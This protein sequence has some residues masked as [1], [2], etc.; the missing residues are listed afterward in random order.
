MYRGSDRLEDEGVLVCS[1]E[2][3][4]SN[5]TYQVLDE[6][7]NEISIPSS[8]LMKLRCSWQSKSRRENFTADGTIQ[9][10]LAPR[11]AAG[12]SY[13]IDVTVIINGHN[14]T[15]S[16]EV[17]V[18]AD[19]PHHWLLNYRSFDK[20]A[21]KFSAGNICTEMK[22][23]ILGSSLQD[24]H[25]NTVTQNGRQQRETVEVV[26]YAPIL[27]VFVFDANNSMDIDDADELNDVTPLVSIPLVQ[28]TELTSSVNNKRKHNIMQSGDSTKPLFI[29]PPTFPEEVVVKLD[30]EVRS[31]EKILLRITEKTSASKIEP[32]EPV[33]CSVGLGVPHKLLISSESYGLM[34]PVLEGNI[35]ISSK[36]RLADINIHVRDKFD[37]PLD[38]KNYQMAFLNIHANGQLFPTHSVREVKNASAILSKKIEIPDSV[39]Q[40]LIT[41]AMSNKTTIPLTE[42]SFTLGFAMTLFKANNKEKLELGF[43]NIQCKV[44]VANTVTALQIDLRDSSQKVLLTK[45][46]ENNDMIIPVGSFMPSLVIRLTSEDGQPFLPDS[47]DY[48]E[49]KLW[50]INQQGKETLVNFKDFYSGHINIGG[51]YTGPWVEIEAKAIELTNAQFNFKVEIVYIERRNGQEILRPSAVLMMRVVP[52]VAERLV[53]KD[54]YLRRLK[55]VVSAVSSSSSSSSRLGEIGRDIHIQALDKYG[56][57]VALSEGHILLCYV[58]ALST[59]VQ[60]PKLSSADGSGYLLSDFPRQGLQKGRKFSCIALAGNGVN[61]AATDGQ[62]TLCF[63]LHDSDTKLLAENREFSFDFTSNGTIT[64]KMQELQDAMAPLQ[65]AI[66]QHNE[67]KQ[68]L[69]LLEQKRRGLA[70]HLRLSGD[71]VMTEVQII[72]YQGMI[73]NEIKVL[74][75]Q[76]KLLIPKKIKASHRDEALCRLLL[77]SNIIGRVVDL[78]LVKDRKYIDIVSLACRRIIDAVVTS[79][80]VSGQKVFQAGLKALPLSLILPFKGQQSYGRRLITNNAGELPLAYIEMHDPQ[81]PNRM[82]DPPGN[83]KYIVSMNA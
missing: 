47:M 49:V 36:G 43:A 3:V 1:P 71:G 83:P 28:N 69:A 37:N 74:E 55:K 51:D 78:A 30:N 5:L 24:Q 8:A 21:V 56:N 48:F 2:E 63:S 32:S 4:I 72:Q 7:G 33:S 38:L 17:E 29:L 6:T 25:G 23:L 39:L 58:A 45:S 41:K 64:R 35:L 46:L 10:I 79:D 9:D 65:L 62:Y 67:L 68:Q 59:E 73:E 14:L 16:L 70:Q 66:S 19:T 40:D 60:A 80:K 52:G 42:S 15:A 61:D 76:K 13:N 18:V 34:N 82:I 77:D 50:Q 81:F 20:K 22:E 26:S 31:H 27:D 54:E 11:S 75:N 57:E 12:P 44:I 53:L